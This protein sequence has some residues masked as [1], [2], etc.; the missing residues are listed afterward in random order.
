MSAHPDKSC[1]TCVLCCKVM[2]VSMPPISD[3]YKPPGVWCEHCAIGKGCRVYAERPT[4]CQQFDCLWLQVP[5]KALGQ[6]LRPDR[7]GVVL[8]PTSD[9]TGIV[10]HCDPKTPTAWRHPKVLPLLKYFAANGK[11]ASARSGKRAWAITTKTEW[12]APADCIVASPGGKLDIHIP[13]EIALAIGMT[14]D[15][16]NL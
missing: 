13:A 10:A 8:Q 2:G 5:N 16:G 4:T 3:A 1:G 15:R 14:A 7:V 6:E 12:E 11:H 9:G